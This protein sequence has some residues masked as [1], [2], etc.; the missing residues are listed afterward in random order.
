MS[1]Q[2]Y[3]DW[4]TFPIDEPSRTYGLTYCVPREELNTIKLDSKFMAAYGHGVRLLLQAWGW[5]TRT[6]SWISPLNYFQVIWTFLCEN[7]KTNNGL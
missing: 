6:K 4:W 2:H 5:D 1:Q 3:Y 7:E